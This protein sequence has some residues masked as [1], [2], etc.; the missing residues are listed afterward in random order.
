[1]IH[2]ERLRR[3]KRRYMGLPGIFAQDPCDGADSTWPRFSL[4]PRIACAGD[5]EQRAELLLGL[6]E[7]RAGDRRAYEA[8][9]DGK[10]ARFP[11]GTYGRLRFPRSCV[12][13]KSPP[14]LAA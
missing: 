10:R 6:R 7:W 5:L 2:A 3:G 9:R 13:A 8:L 12:P 11:A 4:N 14:D 1:M